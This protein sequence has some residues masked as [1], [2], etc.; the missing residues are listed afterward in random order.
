MEK[1]IKYQGEANSE[2]KHFWN[3]NNDFNGNSLEIRLFSQVFERINLTIPLCDYNLP[4]L[5]VL[6][7]TRKQHVPLSAFPDDLPIRLSKFLL[8]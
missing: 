5:F 7:L 3:V 2:W 6:L 4:W 1:R 8:F